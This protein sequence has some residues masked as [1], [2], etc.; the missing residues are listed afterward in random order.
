MELEAKV[1]GAIAKQM[2][3]DIRRVTPDAR[4]VEDLL[5]DSIDAIELAATL[6][7]EFQIEIPDEEL[8]GIRTVG[9]VIEYVRARAPVLQS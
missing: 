9:D 4:F 7:D 8:P 5:V 3:V 2:R 1:K 6:E